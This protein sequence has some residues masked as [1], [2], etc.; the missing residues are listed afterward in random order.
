MNKNTCL[1]TDSYIEF[2]S[3]TT[4]SLVDAGD[5]RITV[6]LSANSVSLFGTSSSITGVDLIESNSMTATRLAI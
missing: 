5:A 2:A 4:V 6:I 1:L 3:P